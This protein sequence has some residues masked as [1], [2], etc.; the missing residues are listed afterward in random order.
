[1]RGGV[2]G[3]VRSN[4]RMAATIKLIPLSLLE[5]LP[6]SVYFTQHCSQQRRH[7]SKH[8]WLMVGQGGGGGWCGGREVQV[9]VGMVGSV[10]INL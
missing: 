1:M 2:R 4:G 7:R 8:L 5:L 6:F 10:D 3:G 9:K